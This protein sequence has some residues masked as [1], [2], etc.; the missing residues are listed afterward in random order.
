MTGQ[1]LTGLRAAMASY[2]KAEQRWSE[3]KTERDRQIV[4]ALQRG[5]PQVLVCE[6]T[7]LTRERIRRIALPKEEDR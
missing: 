3:A 7:D 5:V 6:E 1:D 4:A 2:R